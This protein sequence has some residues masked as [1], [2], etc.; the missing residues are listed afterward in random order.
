MTIFRGMLL[1][2]IV[3]FAAGG[4]LAD[5]P[6]ALEHQ[7]VARHYLLHQPAGDASPRPLLIYL[8]GLRPA[9][10]QNHTQAEID[11]AADR[12]GFVAAYPAA[13]EGRWNYTGQLSDKVKIGDQVADE[14]GFIAELID[15]LASEKIADPSRVYLIGESRG[16]LMVFE[17][18]CRMADRIAAAA[19][20]ITG[21]TEGQRDACA[22]TRPVPVFAVNG[23]A[24]P[25]QRY[26]GWLFPTGRLLSV[27]ETMEYW[28]LQHGCTGQK[29]TMLPHR[30]ET[31]PT[32]IM[33]VQWTGCR[34]GD[35]MRLYRVSGG[36]HQVPSFTAASEAWVREAG[37]QNQ[38]I[39][40]IDAFWDFA[41][42]FGR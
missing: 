7:G 30:V 20:L 40:T 31:D 25:I 24:D 4:A 21:M 39:E 33:L 6:P 2:A 37:R 32:R 5:P 9:G 8:H 29:A 38:D 11:V 16:G 3:Q 19:P 22:P 41:K 18:M 35:A 13:L 42:A 36:G 23:T 28:R 34:G 12:E 14:T 27:P 17:L 10:W 15:R 26:D 1:A